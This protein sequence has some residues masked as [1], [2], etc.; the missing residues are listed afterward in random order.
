MI[1]V[2][3]RFTTYQGT[4][5]LLGMR[6]HFVRFAGCSVAR[7]PIRQQCDEPAALTRKGALELSAE[8]IV[9]GALAEV[10]ERGWLH[11]TGGEPTDQEQGLQ[12]L[13]REARLAGLYVHVQ[14]SGIRRM[15]VQ[16]DWLTISPKGELAQTFGQE[17]VVIDDG[18]VTVEQLRQWE[19]ETKYWCY[20][21]CPLWGREDMTAT[22]RLAGQAGGQWMVTCQMHKLGG[23]K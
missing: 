7:C 5:H 22:V 17:L 13:V 15:P 6:Q 9:T 2:S 1:Y 10:G 11:I 3:K 16:W 14:S 4:G 12:D 20:Y 19:K 18:T 23:F 21:L 8:T